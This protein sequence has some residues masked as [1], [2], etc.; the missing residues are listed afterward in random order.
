MADLKPKLLAVEGV[1]SLTDNA[2]DVGHKTAAQDPREP[3]LFLS[4]KDGYSFTDALAD[5]EIIKATESVKGAH[6]HVVTEDLLGGACVISGAGI[7]PGV[8]IDALKN[9]D[10][11]PTMAKMLGI[12]MQNVDGRVL[13]E[14]LK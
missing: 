5:T 14:A 6:G 10:I 4:A 13:K 1:A 11:A 2:A 12:E 7:K 8:V 9:I 3:D